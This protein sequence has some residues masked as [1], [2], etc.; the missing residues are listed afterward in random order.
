MLQINIDEMLAQLPIALK[1]LVLTI[2]NYLVT[3]SPPH[4]WQQRVN[5]IFENFRSLSVFTKN[6]KFIAREHLWLKGIQSV[7]YI[8]VRQYLHVLWTDNIISFTE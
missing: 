3:H 8:L 7:N 2:F 1:V 5:N 4:M 6:A